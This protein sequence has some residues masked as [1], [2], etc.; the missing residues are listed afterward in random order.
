MLKSGTVPEDPGQ[1]APMVGLCVMVCYSL[2]CVSWCALVELCVMVFTR[3]LE[4][5]HGVYLLS[6]MCVLVEL[7]VMV[8]TRW[9]ELCHG[10]YLLSCMCVMVCTC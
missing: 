7:C 10:V 5:C 6:C 9:L 2:S 4:L 1:L 8:F 3:W